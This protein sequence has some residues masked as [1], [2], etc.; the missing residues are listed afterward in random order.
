MTPNLAR[1]A[2]AVALLLGAALGAQA[3]A[4][5]HRFALQLGDAGARVTTTF[6]AAAGAVELRLPAWVPGSVTPAAGLL[7]GL[8]DLEAKTGAGAAL[9]VTR[10]ERGRVFTVQLAEKGTVQVSYTVPLTGPKARPGLGRRNAFAVP[11]GAGPGAKPQQVRYHEAWLLHG[12]TLCLCV[13]GCRDAKQRVTFTLPPPMS[14]I[15]TCAAGAGPFEVANYDALVDSSFL[16][17]TFEVQP[18][19]DAGAG[20]RVALAGFGT[21]RARGPELWAQLAQLVTLPEQGL[22][23]A[24]GDPFTILLGRSSGPWTVVGHRGGLAAMSHSLRL[25][26]GIRNAALRAAVRTRLRALQPP[27]DLAA[28]TGSTERWWIEGVEGYLAALY[29]VRGGW[30][31][32]EHF[33]TREVSRRVNVWMQDR[34]RH[35]CS[36]AAAGTTRD[37]RGPDLHNGGWLACLLLDVEIRA[38]S[39]GAQSL[40]GALR[41][42]LAA[43]HRADEAAFRAACNTA[44]GRS[45]AAFFAAYIDGTEE[46]PVTATFAEIGVEAAPLPVRAEPAR[47]GSRRI[48]VAS[49]RP[50]RWRVALLPGAAA[51]MTRLRDAITAAR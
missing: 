38:S 27:V 2:A 48:P 22:G 30:A 15:A 14:V 41:Q 37:K 29:S 43:R 47:P 6:P 13:S 49:T 33:W 46:L 26:E 25:S 36:L 5:E 39:G 9:S 8:E 7:G 44:A 17:G 3:P 18:L 20:R 4:V 32:P 1:R 34:D 16:V 31:K 28:P 10:G 23:A 21:D 11:G 45:L 51:A 35:A 24:P 19:P 12:A 42:L 40:E 50:P